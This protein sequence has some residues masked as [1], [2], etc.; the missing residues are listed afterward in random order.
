V[1]EVAKRLNE[2]KETKECNRDLVLHHCRLQPLPAGMAVNGGRENGYIFGPSG[3]GKS[4]YVSKYAEEWC[5]AHPEAAEEGKIFIFSRVAEDQVLDSIRC[6]PEGTEGPRRV[7]LN[8]RFVQIISDPAALEEVTSEMSGGLAI[9]DDVDMITNKDICEA[10]QKFRNDL[11][12]AGRHRDIF[13]LSTSHHAANWKATRTSLNEASFIT[14]FP[15]GGTV[16]G[17]QRILKEYCGLSNQQIARIMG[18]PS[19]W[20]TI[21][22]RFPRYVIYESGIFML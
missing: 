15:H 19:R 10:V 12:E 4:T 16:H 1:L 6:G 17:A 14:L 3:S 13:V 7:A 5:L 20:V 11:L 18:L 9:F 22:I 21:H 8:E 2:E